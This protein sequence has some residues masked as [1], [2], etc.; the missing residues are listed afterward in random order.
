MGERKRRHR[1]K[2]VRCGF[3]K[4]FLG[5][6][7]VVENQ[8]SSQ[9]AYVPGILPLDHGCLRHVLLRASHETKLDG[10]PQKD[11]LSRVSS[12]LRVAKKTNP[13]R[14][15]GGIY[16]VDVVYLIDILSV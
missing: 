12:I 4:V 16:D 13:A 9:G 2:C 3:S 15:R 1:Q 6:H 8:D 7:A 11:P 14:A 10:D 5:T